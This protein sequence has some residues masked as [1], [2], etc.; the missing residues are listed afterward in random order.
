MWDPHVRDPESQ[1]RNCLFDESQ[2]R[3]C[4]FDVSQAWSCLHLRGWLVFQKFLKLWVGTPLSK[5]TQMSLLQDCL[6]F[7]CS[8][9]FHLSLRLA[10]CKIPNPRS[11]VQFVLTCWWHMAVA[12]KKE[13]IQACHITCTGTYLNNWGNTCNFRGK[14]SCVISKTGWLQ[15]SCYLFHTNC[16]L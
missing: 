12:R 14:A 4:L 9:A 13:V 10:S 1:S 6:Y 16:A 7:H 11:Q 8:F 2:T 3:S 5:S 15:V